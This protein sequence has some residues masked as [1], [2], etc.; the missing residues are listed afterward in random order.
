MEVEVSTESIVREARRCAA[1]ERSRS[2]QHP[3]PEKL[4]A[5]VAKRLSEPEQEQV[6]EH[7][8]ICNECSSFVLA[9]AAEDEPE[10]MAEIGLTDDLVEADYRTTSNLV[11]TGGKPT[12][13]EPAQVETFRPGAAW[14]R[15]LWAVA[16]SL[17]IGT[18]VVL[19]GQ[20]ISLHRDLGRL[21]TVNANIPIFDLDPV[22]DDEVRGEEASPVAF[23]DE[24]PSLVIIL[25]VFDYQVFPLY[26]VEISKLQD[27]SWKPI[28]VRGL[29]RSEEGNFTLAIPRGVLP[30]GTFQITLFGV[31]DDD[32]K[33][34]GVY[35]AELSG[36][37]V[38]AADRS[39]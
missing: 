25:N 20:V 11:E 1:R 26:E 7:I 10:L 2:N 34:L 39:R 18:I 32:R 27:P 13:Q 33:S 4:E 22:G 31:R 38:P 30:A 19:S 8:S 6:R 15:P 21:K 9:L 24:A 12:P 3:A 17:L 36:E 23:P 29:K 28:E 5:Y 37:Q 35:I 14:V 16:A